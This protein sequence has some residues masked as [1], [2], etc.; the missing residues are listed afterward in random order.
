MFVAVVGVAAS[1]VWA[2]CRSADSNCGS[3]ESDLSVAMGAL[4]CLFSL[5]T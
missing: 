5:C 3:D 4:F 1:V 2:L